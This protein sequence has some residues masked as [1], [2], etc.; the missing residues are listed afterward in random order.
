MT[1]KTHVPAL[2]AEDVDRGL[3]EGE[4]ETEHWRWLIGVI[5]RASIC[6]DLRIVDLELRVANIDDEENAINYARH[7]WQVDR[8][9]N[10]NNLTG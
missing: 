7:E 9:T 4:G 8:E 10:R 6:T 5:C 1:S 3:T 2:A